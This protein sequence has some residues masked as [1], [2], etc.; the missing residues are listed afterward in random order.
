M[1]MFRNFFDAVEHSTP[2]TE[3]EEACAK[4]E[5]AWGC[6]LRF[7]RTGQNV[8]YRP[9]KSHL[10]PL[11]PVSVHEA[12]EAERLR[13]VS[14]EKSAAWAALQL[15][16]F[17]A[18]PMPFWL[19][20]A[21]ESFNERL[22]QVPVSL[23]TLFGLNESFP[24]GQA[25]KARKARVRREWR[26]RLW[27]EARQ[28]LADGL[29]QSTTKAVEVAI[30]RLKPHGFPFKRTVALKLYSEQDEAQARGMKPYG[31]VKV[32]RKSVGKA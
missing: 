7:A 19:A 28:A 16:A 14:G 21:V 17:H 9:N 1:A 15:C 30:E 26:A 32:V 5:Q 2:M 27:G 18:V 11:G 3:Q 25:G 4:L 10:R 31:R 24:T 6:F 12:L 20:D 29:A 13:F 22:H 8:Q 23:H